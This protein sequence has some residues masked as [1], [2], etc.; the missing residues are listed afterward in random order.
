MD[1]VC[2]LVEREVLAERCGWRAS[3]DAGGNSRGVC[4]GVRK[5]RVS[6]LY[7]TF[8]HVSLLVQNLLENHTLK[9]DA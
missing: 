8:W 7:S 4:L 3:G 2:S 1:A 6:F 5:T 9:S